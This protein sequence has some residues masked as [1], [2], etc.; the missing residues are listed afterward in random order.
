MLKPSIHA[1]CSHNTPSR[2]LLTTPLHNANFLAGARENAETQYSCGLQPQHPFTTPLND[3]PS[4]K[5][6]SSSMGGEASDFHK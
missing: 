1:D 3:T 4:G 5:S 2:H 6:A